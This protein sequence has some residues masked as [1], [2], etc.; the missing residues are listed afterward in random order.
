MLYAVATAAVLAVLF[1]CTRA[2]DPA[3]PLLLNDNF[4]EDVRKI[5]ERVLH[6]NKALLKSAGRRLKS[7]FTHRQL[8]FRSVCQH[9]T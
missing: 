9:M 7:A 3:D 2:A 1:P 4:V 8:L 6:R 5:Y